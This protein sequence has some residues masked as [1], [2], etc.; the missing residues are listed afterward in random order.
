MCRLKCAFLCGSMP[1][2]SIMGDAIASYRSLHG[3]RYVARLW[4]ARKV[5]ANAMTFKGSLVCVMNVVC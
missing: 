1:V 2:E 4:K 3:I 5:W